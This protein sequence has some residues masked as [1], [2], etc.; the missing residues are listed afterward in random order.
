MNC[1]SGYPYF[2]K[3]K[4]RSEDFITIID[5]QIT[6]YSCIKD[7]IYDFSSKGLPLDG[8]ALWEIIVIQ[9]TTEWKY[10]SGLKEDQIAIILRENHTVT[11][12]LSLMNLIA[13]SFGDQVMDLSM[14]LKNIPR[15]PKSNIVAKLSKYLLLFMI[16]PGHLLIASLQKK[17]NRKLWKAPN[18]VHK[19]NVAY[20][21]EDGR[22]LVEKIKIMKRDI[23]DVSF[24]EILIAAISASLNRHFLKVSNIKTLI[25]NSVQIKYSK[26]KTR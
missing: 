23:G 18:I 13:N 14:Y 10:K 24:T 5:T 17:L 26:N 21:C 12:G 4:F 2:L 7:I 3:E 8:K 15:S 22:G 11:D 20:K 1:V 25:I 9:A 6:K 16:V 19:Q